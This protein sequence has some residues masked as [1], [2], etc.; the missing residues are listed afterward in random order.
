[1]MNSYIFEVLKI[2]QNQQMQEK[3]TTEKG[4]KNTFDRNDLH[5]IF[6]LV[7]ELRFFYHNLDLYFCYAF[8]P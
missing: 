7:E 8:P 1:M 5:E 4:L 6:Y 3:I 2:V